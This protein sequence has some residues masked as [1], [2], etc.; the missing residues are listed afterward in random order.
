MTANSYNFSDRTFQGLTAGW[1]VTKGTLPYAYSTYSVIETVYD[2]AQTILFQDPV[3]VGQWL[4]LDPDDVDITWAADGGFS[5]NF[6]GS[7]DTGVT[8]APAA[9][10]NA[11]VSVPTHT[12][13][14]SD[15][16]GSA[17]VGSTHY[18][19]GVTPPELW[20]Y[21]SSGWVH[22]AVNTNTTYTVG[23]GGLTSN[24][25]TNTDH[26]KLNGV[27]D[28][29]TNNNVYNGNTSTRGSTTGTVGDFFYDT[30]TN[31]LFVWE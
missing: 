17:V 11:N 2:G 6:G 7:F 14:G 3:Y 21:G 25:F 28:S 5:L 12:T 26:S 10:L 22:Q 23:D 29:A 4:N 9:M 27:A 30:D 24:N 20:I 16:S 15:P 19:T 18:K 8:A 1:S 31:E 13:S